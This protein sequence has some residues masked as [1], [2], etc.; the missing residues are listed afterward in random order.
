MELCISGLVLVVIV[1]LGNIA[2]L[3]LPF[4]R[5]DLPPLLRRGPVLLAFSLG[6]FESQEFRRTRP[7][8]TPSWYDSLK[9]SPSLSSDASADVA[10]GCIC[11]AVRVHLNDSPQLWRAQM[12]HP[13]AATVFRKYLQM[14]ARQVEI[15]RPARLT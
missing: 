12:L 5:I 1:M 7:G 9:M 6:F 14:K 3:E 8:C 11:N 13:G 4:T 10:P 15:G 2:D